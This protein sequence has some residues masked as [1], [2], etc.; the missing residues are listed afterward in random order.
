ML[1]V[2]PA[3]TRFAPLDLAG[4]FTL[5]LAVTPAKTRFAPSIWPTAS[6]RP[7]RRPRPGSRLSTWPTASLS[8]AGAPAKTRFAPSA[9]PA[10]ARRCR[11]WAGRSPA[12]LS[13]WPAAPCRCW[14]SGPS[15][16]SPRLSTRPAAPCRCWRCPPRTDL[17]GPSSRVRRGPARASDPA[18]GA[19][20]VLAVAPAENDHPGQRR[21][22][23]TQPAPL[24]P[25]G[26]ACRCWR[27][28]PR[29]ITLS[30][31]QPRPPRPSPRLSP[32]RRRRAG[33]GDAGRDRSPCRPS[34]ASAAAL[35]LD[36]ADG[37][38]APAETDHAVGPGATS[39]AG[40]DATVAS[41]KG[42]SNRRRPQEG[43]PA[44][45][46]I[47]TPVNA[48]S[49]GSN[50]TSRNEES[51][52]TTTQTEASP[53]KPRGTPKFRTGRYEQTLGRVPIGA[54]VNY[55]DE[56]GRHASATARQQ[57]GSFRQPGGYRAGEVLEGRLGL[58]ELP[59]ALRPRRASAGSPL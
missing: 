11:P 19:V 25:A 5:L 35:P 26:G 29:P 57:A 46:A 4:G 40:G 13:T 28:Q 52:R 7:G 49:L 30:A 55:Q 17:P 21:V 39:A 9:W 48:S 15:R 32:G 51:V 14:Q 20:P 58:P 1:A 42:P 44:R 41:H 36:L 24:D 38:A 12:R 18:G 59:D 8:P 27:C 43:P 56:H 45:N 23:A 50:I 22:R 33:A 34:A 6:R 2:T 47:A 31:Q 16:P 10:P 3:K 37:A 53:Q 54:G